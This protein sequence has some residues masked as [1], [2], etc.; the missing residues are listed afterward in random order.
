VLKTG[1]RF[2]C[3]P[4]L[5]RTSR[6]AVG[7]PVVGWLGAAGVAPAAAVGAACYR[8]VP[9]KHTINFRINIFMV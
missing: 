7:T 6:W 8:S 1:K 2:T 5:P 9:E 3:I 4:C